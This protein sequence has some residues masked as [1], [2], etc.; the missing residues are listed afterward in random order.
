MLR[1][2]RDEK[3]ANSHSKCA[4]WYDISH[5]RM[6]T[7][8]WE[9]GNEEKESERNF[10]HDRIITILSLS[11]DILMMIIIMVV[12]MFIL[13]LVVV[14]VVLFPL[15]Q[16]FSLLSA[17]WLSMKLFAMNFISGINI[18]RKYFTIDIYAP[19]DNC[20]WA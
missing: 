14:V 11:T 13:I 17:Y 19:V 8:E 20:Q 9:T 1:L 18:N 15:P 5:H 2:I 12:C 16:A 10:K 4:M 7:N 6:K 3:Y